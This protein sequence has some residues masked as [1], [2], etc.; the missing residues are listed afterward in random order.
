MSEVS[1]PIGR[2]SGDLMNFISEIRTN[3]CR[4][5]RIHRDNRNS[6]NPKIRL[7]GLALAAIGFGL[8]Y[9][10]IATQL[11]LQGKMVAIVGAPLAMGMAGLVELLSG[12]PFYKIA[13][14]WDSMHGLVRYLLGIAII[15]M[16]FVVLCIGVR[17]FYPNW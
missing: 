6:M 16:F 15:I 17:M 1:A 12:Y 4:P 10:L 9:L 13:E 2:E 11:A 8:T 14:K 3:K 7:R 5:R